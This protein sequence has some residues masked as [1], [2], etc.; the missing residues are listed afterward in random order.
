MA[1]YR[2]KRVA[3][4]IH[5]ELAKRLLLEIKD[6]RVVP[7]SIDPNR[8]SVEELQSLPG[9]AAGRAEAIAPK[10]PRA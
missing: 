8:A 6:P 4:M 3:E 7:I 2:P 1:G 5:K 10:R 9:I